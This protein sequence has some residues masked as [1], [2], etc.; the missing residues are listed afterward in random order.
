MKDFK[1]KL[2]VLFVYLLL[3]LKT[4]ILMFQNCS[5]MLLIMKILIVRINESSS[6]VTT[7]NYLENTDVYYC[8]YLLSI[9]YTIRYHFVKI[10]LFLDFHGFEF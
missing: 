7:H 5:R 6:G 2:S 8:N 3:V 9:L 4:I 10:Y 1:I